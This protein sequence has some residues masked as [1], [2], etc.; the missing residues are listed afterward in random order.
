M[1]DGVL[2]A[3]GCG[4]TFLGLGGAYVYIRAHIFEPAAQAVTARASSVSRPREFSPG[5]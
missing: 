4:V 1:S 3:I 2:L 5:S